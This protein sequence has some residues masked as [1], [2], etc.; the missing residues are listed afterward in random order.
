MLDLQHSCAQNMPLL[1]AGVGAPDKRYS[2]N[3]A[4]LFLICA[5]AMVV[6]ILAS[7]ASQEETVAQ[8]G[9]CCPGDTS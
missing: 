9:G 3:F 7:C 2:C 6:L 8:E 4:K 5:A 1:R